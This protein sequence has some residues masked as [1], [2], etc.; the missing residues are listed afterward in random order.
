MSWRLQRELAD[1]L[2]LRVS[3]GLGGNK[4]V[5]Q[6]ASRIAK[7]AGLVTVA[8]GEESAFLA[9]L[10]TGW[11]P[12]MSA[13]QRKLLGLLGVRSIGMLAQVPVELAECVLGPVGKTLV[14]RAQGVDK[15]PVLAGMR[16]DVFEEGITFEKDMC[17]AHR[18]DA[19]LF[20]LSEAMGARLRRLGLGVKWLKLRLTYTDRYTVEHTMTLT[21]AAH[22]D[23]HIY[24]EAVLLLKRAYRRRVKV[25]A[26]HLVAV[27]PVP[28]PGQLELFRPNNG[29]LA[30]LCRACDLI[31]E[32]YPG[33]TVLRY[34]KTFQLDRFPETP[35]RKEV[36]PAAN[37]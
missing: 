22:I 10:P 13:S 25:R 19:H 18:I 36:R 6:V 24:E 27:N 31:R 17:H 34:G 3:L 7:L 4:L 29:K 2:G 32:K 33:Q 9:P 8:A 15:R 5:S 26:L 14:E 1:R 20:A 12:G 23:R 37:G 16:R 11:L 35:E 21:R 28:I 30:S